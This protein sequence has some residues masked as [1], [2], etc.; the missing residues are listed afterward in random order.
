M[1]RSELISAVIIACVILGA[2]WYLN[3]SSMRWQNDPKMLEAAAQLEGIPLE[4]GEWRA[5]RYTLS[6]SEIR[7]T[8]TKGAYT[9]HLSSKRTR[10]PS[11]VMLLCGETRNLATHPP[12]VCFTGLGYVQS[13]DTVQVK[14]DANGDD[15]ALGEFIS[16]D[17]VPSEPGSRLQPIRVYWAWSRDGRN[18][19]APQNPRFAFSDA[20]YLYKVYVTR[21][22]L[23]DRA[24]KSGSTVAQVDQC[25][26]I[27]RQFLAELRKVI[28]D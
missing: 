22:N 20:P 6:E 26:T 1:K 9:A 10:M 17:F 19:E 3:T 5:E 16:V 15:P 11:S 8:G 12:T 25:E 13:S 23:P 24:D 18:W 7:Q 4:F 14:I 21:G 2:G 28:K 27:M